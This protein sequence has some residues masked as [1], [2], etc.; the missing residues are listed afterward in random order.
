MLLMLS[1]IHSKIF[2]FFHSVSFIDMPATLAHI[3]LASSITNFSE[4]YFLT[5]KNRFRYQPDESSFRGTT[6]LLSR[7]FL[8]DSSYHRSTAGAG[9]LS[10]A[11][12]H[13]FTTRSPSIQAALWIPNTVYSSRSKS[14]HLGF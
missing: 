7:A 12:F 2:P 9:S 11:T 6:S 4:Q 1:S 3:F 13:R 10:R 5:Q 8:P 14:E